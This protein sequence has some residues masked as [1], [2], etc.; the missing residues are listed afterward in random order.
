MF[1]AVPVLPPQF[2]SQAGV[3]QRNGAWLAS[4][5]DA[6]GAS[7]RP[8]TVAAVV[9]QRIEYS[10][11]LDWPDVEVL[12]DGGWRPGEVRMQTQIDDGTWE[13][14]V[15]WRAQEGEDHPPGST[16]FPAEQV[17]WRPRVD[18]AGGR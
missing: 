16:P 12:V 11:P 6:L 13:L 3:S 8:D 17:P 18:R 9:R 4:H 5:G 2:P 15:Q 1:S 7:A 10:S 14:N